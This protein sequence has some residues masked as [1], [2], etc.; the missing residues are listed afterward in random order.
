M[1]LIFS[2]VYK[3]DFTYERDDG[4]ARSWP[5]HILTNRHCVNEISSIMCIHSPDNFSDHVPIL[6]EL[7]FF[8]PNVGGPDVFSS[9]DNTSLHDNIDWLGLDSASIE[10]YKTC[11]Q[12][13]LPTL[14]VELQECSTPD[15]KLHQLAID[16]ACD[17]LFSCLYCAGQQC[18]P[19]FS[20]RYGMTLLDYFVVKLCS[21][22][23]CGRI[24]VVLLV[25]FFRKS[26]KKPS[27]VTSMLLDL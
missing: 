17:K 26:G 2:H 24:M 19:Q 27:L 23:V 25:V 12:A 13:S 11:V 1:L 9:D 14:S 5:Y 4:L 10:A 15:C 3:I 16:S 8:L 18:L 7:G 6:F 22:I 20:K 21:G